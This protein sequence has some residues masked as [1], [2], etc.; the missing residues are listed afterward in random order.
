[1]QNSTLSQAPHNQ[2]VE[3]ESHSIRGNRSSFKSI[4][5]NVV[6]GLATA[7]TLNA[8]VHE[9]VINKNSA[10]TQKAKII[11]EKRAER[12]EEL[13]KAIR[14]TGGSEDDIVRLLWAAMH[15][16]EDDKFFNGESAIETPKS[17]SSEEQK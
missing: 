17:S 15:A 13:I 14:N 7:I 16:K 1:M 11:A 2:P 9:N 4:L 12:L 10:P 6:A 8:C 5:K 3:S